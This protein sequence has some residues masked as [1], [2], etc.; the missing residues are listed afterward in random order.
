M[1]EDAK[2]GQWCI[3]RAPLPVYRSHSP[4]SFILKISSS[5]VGL[6]WMYLRKV[7]RG[8]GPDCFPAIPTMM[9]C[10][11]WFRWRSK[12]FIMCLSVGEQT[13]VFI[14]WS[15]LPVPL[16]SVCP[17]HC[18]STTLSQTRVMHS[19]HCF[20]RESWQPYQ[21]PVDFPEVFEKE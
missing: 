19:Q 6:H 4:S 13:T 20:A 21:E 3:H 9:K 16:L 15:Q 2:Q 14:S 17:F 5:C 8:L 18:L 12:A 7:F 11:N 1:T 10:G